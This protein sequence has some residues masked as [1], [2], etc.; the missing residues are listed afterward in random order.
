MKPDTCDSASISPIAASSLM[1]ACF[2]CALLIAP[3]LQL[4]RA[5]VHTRVMQ[6]VKS[7]SC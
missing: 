6:S 3:V 1:G 2:S 5:A 4:G 7:K